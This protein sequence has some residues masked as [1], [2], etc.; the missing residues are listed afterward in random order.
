MQLQK[1]WKPNHHVD[2]LRWMKLADSE[3]T[4]VGTKLQGE[5]AD[6]FL[7]HKTERLSDYEWKSAEVTLFKEF[8]SQIK[9]YMEKRAGSVEWVFII[10]NHLVH[11][12]LNL[13]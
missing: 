3:N 7:S 1:E 11:Q 6:D 10:L 12:S 8:P 4:D 5:H 2:I 13:I 9:K